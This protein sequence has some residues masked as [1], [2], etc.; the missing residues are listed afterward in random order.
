MEGANARTLDADT[1]PR[2]KRARLIMTPD[3]L[4]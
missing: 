1:E 2:R 4:S 3:P